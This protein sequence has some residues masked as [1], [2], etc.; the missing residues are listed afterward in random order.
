MIEVGVKSGELDQRRCS[1]CSICR[2]ERDTRNARVSHWP[3]HV[4]Y[5]EL[6]S[7]E[8]GYYVVFNTIC[9]IWD[10]HEVIVTI[11]PLGINSALCSV[12]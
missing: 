5:S 10:H 4:L 11:F 3:Q 6:R 9:R 12:T 8:Q 1:V 7:R 2:F